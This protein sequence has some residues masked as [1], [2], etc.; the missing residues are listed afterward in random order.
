MID[1]KTGTLTTI[2]L[3]AVYH[4]KVKRIALRFP[5]DAELIK[6]AK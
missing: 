2:K 1:E 3:E 5:Y 6:L 4:E